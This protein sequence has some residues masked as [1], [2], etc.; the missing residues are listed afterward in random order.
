MD[1]RLQIIKILHGKK[2]SYKDCEILAD[3]IL[4][5]PEIIVEMKEKADLWDKF[6]AQFRSGDS[7]NRVMDYLNEL[8]KT[9][10]A[11]AEKEAEAR[12]WEAAFMRAMNEADMEIKERVMFQEKCEALQ[13]ELK[14]LKEWQAKAVKASAI[15]HQEIIEINTEVESILEKHKQ[16]DEKSPTLKLKQALTKI[17]G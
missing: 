7:I 5:L 17:M 12:K 6:K 3:E 4:S 10:A 1:K 9:K 14:A 8:D 15:L 16:P 2:T 13:S 11:L